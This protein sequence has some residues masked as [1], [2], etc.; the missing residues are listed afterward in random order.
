MTF[1]GGCMVLLILVLIGLVLGL[2]ARR[3]DAMNSVW[4]L[5]EKLQAIQNRSAAD[6]FAEA[7]RKD[8]FVARASLQRLLGFN[9]RDGEDI[10]LL[11][12]VL[13]PTLETCGHFEPKAISGQQPGPPLVYTLEGQLVRQVS[14]VVLDFDERFSVVRGVVTVR[15]PGQPDS[16]VQR[17]PFQATSVEVEANWLRWKQRL[18]VAGQSIGERTAPPMLGL[19]A[20]VKAARDRRAVEEMLQREQYEDLQELVSNEVVETNDEDKSV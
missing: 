20:R 18:D 4:E 15:E 8:P 12:I 11:K 13:P 14:Q 9:I 19:R 1:L 10:Q 5:A 7:E 3:R 6:L 2:E 16:E 17:F